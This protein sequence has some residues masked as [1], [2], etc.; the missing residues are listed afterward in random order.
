MR[1]AWVMTLKPGNA[2]EYKQRHDAIWPEL[3]AL[4]Q[5]DGVRNYSIYRYG[6][7]LFAYLERDT[8]PDPGAAIDP[9]VWRWW[10]SM[11]PLM[12]TNP[13]SSPLMEAV[14]E[15]FHAP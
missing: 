13:D 2:A 10:Q 11:A 12:E 14:E 4:M 7:K 5:R 6:L 1:Q 3:L 15:M 9:I 8:P